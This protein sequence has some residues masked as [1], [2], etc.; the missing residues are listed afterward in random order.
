MKQPIID[1]HMLAARFINLG[2]YNIFMDILFTEF[3]MLSVPVEKAF[4]TFI[5]M[6]LN[7][8]DEHLRGCRELTSVEA[9]EVISKR[10]KRIWGVG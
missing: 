2:E 10:F 9:V 7:R 5:R 1:N 8:L 6:I 3:G 4:D